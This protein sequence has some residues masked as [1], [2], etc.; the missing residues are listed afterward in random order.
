MALEPAIRPSPELTGPID[1]IQGR[2]EENTRRMGIPS[3]L[4]GPG[5]MVPSIAHALAAP[6]DA[7][8][9][10]WVPFGA[11]NIGGH[12]QALA[13]DPANPSTLYA[14]TAQGG[15][16]RTRDAGDTWEP[17]G[18]PEDAFPVGALAVAPSNPRI[19][20]AGTGEPITLLGA[21]SVSSPQQ[22]LG[23]F[24][25]DTGVATP[26]FVNEVGPVPA[27]GPA[28]NGAANTYARIVVDPRTHERC[29]IASSTGLW[30]REAGPV[31]HR[32]PLP[33]PAGVTPDVTD[34]A[35][36]ERWNPDRPDTYR[37][38]AGVAHQG[39]YRG[40]Y[41]PATGATQW[42]LNG[43]G[44]IASGGAATEIVGTG[45]RFR[46]FFQVG[47][48][49]HT[50]GL[51]PEQSQTI[52]AI[53]D[54]THLTVGAA[55]A[56]VVPAGTQY[57]KVP[58]PGPALPTGAGT[59][60]YA[61][62]PPPPPPPVHTVNGA[63]TNFT[64]FFH[65]GD[66]IRTTGLAQ[67]VVAT[68]ATVVNNTTL[69]VAA[70]FGAAIPAGTGYQNQPLS[71][72]GLGLGAG[73]ISAAAGS[74]EVVGVGTSFTAFFRVGEE[75][76]T[77]G[78]LPV[79]GRLIA[80]IPDDTHLRVEMPFL[81][82][83]PAGT[84]YVRQ[85]AAGVALPAPGALARIR[86]AVC[87]TRPEHVY[88]L[89]SNPQP[90]TSF[91]LPLYHSGDGGDTW[92]V[93]TPP[94]PPGPNQGPQCWYYL[95][96]AVHPY[97]PSLVL[98]GGM[99]V[100]RSTD[101]GM[102]W[103]QVLDWTRY[104]QG[105]RAQHADHHDMLFDHV[106]RT[107]LWV[108]NDGGLSMVSDITRGNPSIDRTWRKR[109]HGI[110]AAQFNDITVHPAYPFIMGG[111]LQDNGTYLGFGGPTWYHIGF[112]DGGELALEQNNPRLFYVNSQNNTW[113]VTVVLGNTPAPASPQFLIQSPVNA[114]QAPPN[115]VMAVIKNWLFPTG[116]FVGV[117]EHH[118]VAPQHFLLADTGRLLVTN[119]GGANFFLG[120]IAGILPN[121][122]VTALGFG[123]GATG[124]AWVGTSRGQVFRG[125]YGAAQPA[126]PANPLAPTWRA[127]GGPAVGGVALGALPIPGAAPNPWIS[128]I[129][130]HPADANY[131]AIA[132]G[133]NGAAA[134]TQGR[135]YLSMDRGVS[136][137][138][139]TGL[140]AP[141]QQSLPP[142]PVSSLAFDPSV[143]AGSPQVLF[144]GTLAGVYVIRNLPARPPAAGA[145]VPAF[146]PQW[147]SFNNRQL[148]APA[149][150]VAGQ[151]PLV[152][153][154]D[155]VCVTHAPTP[156]AAPGSPEA[157][158]RQL[159]ICS[160]FGRGMY[161]CDLSAPVGA[162]AVGGGPRF[163]LFIRQYVVEDGMGYP[164]LA[165]AALNAAPPAPGLGGDPRMPAG[166]IQFD[167]TQAYDIRVDRPP[168]NFFEEVLDG[169]EF[170]ESL[171]LDEPEPGEPNMV[172]VQ[173]HTR[174]WDTLRDVTVHLFF[175][176]APAPAPAGPPLP[177]LQADFWAH[178]TDLVLPAPSPA[179]VA[180]AA[181]WQRAGTPQPLV[182]RPNQP[183]V[184][185]FEWVPPASLGGGHVAL[186]AV[187][188]SPSDPLP[189]GLPTVMQTLLLQERRAALR[190]IRVRPFVPD[191][192][193]RDGVEDAGTGPSVA[194]G[195]R[196]PDIIV[197]QGAP[198][199]PP[200]EA[201]RDLLDTRPADRLRGVGDNFIYVRVHNRKA[202]EVQAQVELWRVKPIIPLAPGEAA[203]PPF[204]QSKW[205]QDGL[206][207]D[208][209]PLPAG[210]SAVT[211]PPRGWGAARFTWH[212]PPNPDPAGTDP[213]PTY[214][215]VALVS[216]VPPGDPKP[217]KADVDSFENFW[218]FFRTL[219]SAGNAAMRGVRWVAS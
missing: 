211:L 121:E 169:V 190:V 58:P 142:C 202:V 31:F 194:F 187:C 70:T 206:V 203:A 85:P 34:V 153:V 52:T 205:S 132:T 159:L 45:T 208:G 19:L 189:G 17:L 72:L 144:A 64:T 25:C 138:D 210:T 157:A 123:P 110:L 115:D 151:L 196:S 193:I 131:V 79:Q 68:V 29:W 181:A 129:A 24:R 147:F 23:F 12:I 161:A 36:A 135:V 107:R 2:A 55:F 61:V 117:I 47:D 78:L 20:Y 209:A 140:G 82:P 150:V 134:G 155:L 93:Q 49:I 167:L 6:V 213:Y 41:D 215:L 86:L 188:T 128:R 136:W 105:D 10:P 172:Y 214:L 28:P 118:P 127:L 62:P 122:Q 53:A 173:V 95:T 125:T 21:V 13:Q 90:G 32:E 92:R 22:G 174:G 84:A 39:I 69:T 98:A 7:P 145:A 200:A 94:D 54:D 57:F 146:N 156:G 99:N 33:I 217:S 83:V 37:L 111:G 102:S 106:N 152:L 154:N 124:D 43:A 35:L 81:A 178:V 160:T 48:T 139:V 27:A 9:R 149:P 182:V 165:P 97:E 16:F 15:V 168:F 126:P 44:T 59:I 170:D 14:G 1:E 119:D 8:P 38:Y 87:K 120:G 216:A 199:A 195:G 112:A 197:V 108:A 218:D 176:P 77:T 184:A 4:F 114:D 219:R 30:R 56:P 180:P 148:P 71:G 201:F 116:A 163:R 18:N 50:S 101:F 40:V 51:A 175:A 96:L 113:G 88:A 26:R 3:T 74:A 76:R 177:D 65:A 158:A 11:R 91:M 75:I 143:P 130:V 204:D 89:M 171:V 133:G 137:A 191:I 100:F 46:T 166:T 164:R 66:E 103:A 207:G 80:A 141:P 212:E 179:P 183:A 63:G 104:D 162:P 5:V 67:D 109:S 42:D 198:A 73:T 192:Y 186:L 60:S 185:R